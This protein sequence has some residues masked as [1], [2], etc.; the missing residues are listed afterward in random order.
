MTKVANI[1]LAG[2]VAFAATKNPDETFNYFSNG[3]CAFAQYLKSLGYEQPWVGGGEFS[4]YSG[5]H[6]MYKEGLYEELV[7]LELISF[8]EQF[9]EGYSWDLRDGLA[10]SGRTWGKI[11]EYFSAVL[12]KECT[13]AI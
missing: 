3:N 9:G 1:S 12:P 4:R 13:P 5:K 8:V 10:H 7:P 2:F 6:P 11:H